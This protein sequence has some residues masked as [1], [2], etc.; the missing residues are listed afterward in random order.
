MIL[1]RDGRSPLGWFFF[2]QIWVGVFLLFSLIRPL[3]PGFWVWIS[4]KRSAFDCRRVPRGS[5]LGHPPIGLAY[6]PLPD[7]FC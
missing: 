6:G 5:P 2:L 1:L 3:L 4:S 7:D